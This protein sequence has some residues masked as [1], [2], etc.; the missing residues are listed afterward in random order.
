MTEPTADRVRQLFAYDPH[1]GLFTRRVR[2]SNRVKVGQVAGCVNAQGYVLLTVDGARYLAHR[3][4]WLHVH[5]VMPAAA[6]DHINGDRTDNRLANLREADNAENLWNR[7]ASAANTSG[8]KGVCFDRRTG[9]WRAAIKARDQYRFLGRFRT[10][11]EAHQA[12]AAA[13][14]ELHGAY[15]NPGAAA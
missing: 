1:T 14:A 7:G 5:G 10:A 13:A 3:L 9:R 4:A 15:A 2:T 11:S 6:I 8:F 12:Y